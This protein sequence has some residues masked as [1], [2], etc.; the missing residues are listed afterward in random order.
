M[1]AT[2]YLM[3]F[4]G[5]LYGASA[6][7]ANNIARYTLGFAFPLFVVQMYEGLGTGWATSLL[8]FVSLAMTPIPFA[9]YIWG[10]KLRSMSRYQRS[11]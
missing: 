10:P 11:G 3:D 2:L 9:F 8:G 7:G 4:Y 1:S 6:M 5:P